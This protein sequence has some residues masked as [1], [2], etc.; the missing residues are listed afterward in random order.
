[1]TKAE[2]QRIAKDWSELAH[3]QRKTKLEA[4]TLYEAVTHTANGVLPWIKNHW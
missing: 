4:E 2:W 1:V 3:Y